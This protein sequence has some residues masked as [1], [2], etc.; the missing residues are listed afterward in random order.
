[1]GCRGKEG[2]GQ[3]EKY[4]PGGGSQVCQG[5]VGGGA[6]EGQQDSTARGVGEA[7]E[8][9]CSQGTKPLFDP[10]QVS[11]CPRQQKLPTG[12]PTLFTTL[13]GSPLLSQGFPHSSLGSKVYANSTPCPEPPPGLCGS[14]RHSFPLLTTGLGQVGL[15]TPLVFRAACHSSFWSLGSNPSSVTH[16]VCLLPGP[17]S[18]PICKREMTLTVIGVLWIIM[19][20]K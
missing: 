14:P 12:I 9:R 2:R 6:V 4:N 5:P 10:I 1:M 3:E 19:R 8:Q 11:S 13:T 16:Q 17:L 20:S 7:G 15:S 18:F